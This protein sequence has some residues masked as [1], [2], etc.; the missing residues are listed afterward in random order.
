MRVFLIACALVLVAGLVSAFTIAVWRPAPAMPLNQPDG[1]PLRGAYLARLAGCVA[2]HTAAEGEAFAG[3]VP[4]ESPFGTFVS[5]NIT[6][7][8]DVGIGRWTRAE[9]ARAVRQG[10]SP[11]GHAYYPSFPYEFY[12]EMTNRD[13]ADLW[14]AI[15][16]LPEVQDAAAGHEVEFPFNMRV[17]LK[18]WRPLFERRYDHSPDP[19]RSVS[20]NR[21]KYMVEGVAHCGACHTP[22][23]LAGGLQTAESLAGN[24]SMMDGSQAPSLSSERLRSA[25]WTRQGLVAAL[26]TG[27]LPDGDVFGGAMAE[28]VNE[29]TSLLLQQ[30]LEDMAAYL[31]DED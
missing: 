12:G 25:G 6:P 21:G 17:G 18:F 13:I 24:P 7:D 1:D 30:H 20:W 4:L 29:S 8:P 3:G 15:N 2:C 31:L 11:E 26:R 23:N 19:N 27:I 16:A 22:R 5:P 10:I 14:A 28:V 9:F